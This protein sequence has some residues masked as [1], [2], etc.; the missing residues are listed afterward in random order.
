MDFSSNGD[1]I[2]ESN[3]YNKNRMKPRHFYGI[4]YNG[5]PLFY[6]QE[7]NEY[8]YQKTIDSITNGYMLESQLI[9]IKLYNDDENDYYLSCTSSHL[10]HCKTGSKSSSN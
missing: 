1:L 4:K 3:I 2:I 9:T 8:K 5:R 6:D 7:N 10:G